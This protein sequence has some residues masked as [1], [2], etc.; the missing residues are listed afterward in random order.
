MTNEQ[1]AEQLAA[2]YS[3]YGAELTEFAGRI[4]LQSTRDISDEQFD[5]AIQMHIEDPQ[6]GRWLPK[7]ADIIGAINGDKDEA[8]LIAWGRIIEAAR[9]GGARIGLDEAASSA[10]RDI[11]GM[12][13]VQRSDESQ[14]SYLQRRFCD[15]FKAYSA[16]E[17]RE[18]LMIGEDNVVRIST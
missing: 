8:S 6:R 14:N 15:S 9:A 3:F 13:A 18:A 7:P 17:R 12:A 4:W 2:L 1:R 5:R 11:G 16:R 10:L